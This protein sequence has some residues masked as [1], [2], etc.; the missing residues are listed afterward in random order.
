MDHDKYGDVAWNGT[1]PI[2]I[3]TK[4]PIYM[5]DGNEWLRLYKVKTCTRLKCIMIETYAQQ[6][7]HGERTFEGR[8]E[9]GKS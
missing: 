8:G 6:E 7:I 1:R 2:W 4:S 9:S 5:G 3:L